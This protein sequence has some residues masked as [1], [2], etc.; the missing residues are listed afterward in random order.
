MGSIN[1]DHNL[2][3]LSHL[4]KDEKI[5]P[6]LFNIKSELNEE[7]NLGYAL[8]VYKMQGSQK[9]NVVIFIDKGGKLW[10]KR[11]IYTAISRGKERSVLI[12]REKDFVS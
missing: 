8:T 5:N 1:D 7:Y 2:I 6:D 10:D 4:M 11:S 12:T 3:G 9:E